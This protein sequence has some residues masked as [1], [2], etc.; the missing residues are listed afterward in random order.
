M[1]ST[2][3]DYDILVVG[4]GLSGINTS[5]RLQTEL[6][7]HRFA[8]LEARDKI[9]GTWSFWEYPGVRTDSPMGIFGLSWAPWTR[10]ENMADA[11]DI[12]N[13]MEDAAR[14][15]GIYDKIKFRHKVTAMRWDGSAGKNKWSLDVEI[16]SD[17]GTTRT[18]VIT[19]RWVVCCGGY[20]NYKQ[21]LETVIPG[22]ERFKGTVVHPQFW[23]EHAAAITGSTETNEDASSSENTAKVGPWA[24]KRVI[25]IGSGATAVT[26]LP[27]LA[28]MSKSVTILQRS[29][30]YVFPIPRR[31]G[32]GIFLRSILPLS[33]ASK[34]IWMRDIL[35]QEL[36]VAFLQ[37]FP[38]AGRKVIM[39]EIKKRMPK[40]FDVGTH[41]N[42][43]YRPFEQRLCLCPDGDFFEAFKK[44]GVGIVTD[45]IDTVTET[46]IKTASGQTLDAD[47]IITATGLRLCLVPA[48]I[49]VYISQDGQDAKPFSITDHFVWNG[50]M[51][52][53]VPNLGSIT[54]YTVGT[55]TPGA[56]A[57]A[58]SLIRVIKKADQLGATITVPEL[59]PELKKT[60]PRHP[61][62]PNSSTYLVTARDRMPVSSGTAPWTYPNQWL[63]DALFMWFGNVTKGLKFS[64]IK[65]KQDVVNGKV[66]T[67]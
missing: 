34:I 16:T 20:Y 62:L 36:F 58:R 6:P 30:S 61:I 52:E 53:N 42:P 2:D 32:L 37:T 14:T 21:A 55:W 39:S 67:A 5:Y 54:A 8:V 28:E 29:P 17:E 11:R 50:F 4:A 41:F 47:V 64:G 44:P 35:R 13:Y 19:A 9:G 51:V 7:S 18:E 1:A 40:G 24:D 15:H 23:A 25:I 10:D 12:R 65:G 49:P 59:D 57:R 56:D 31:D 45:T 26:L 60:L 66:K 38:N 3:T 43:K 33:L 48:D 27:S 63:T 22:I 46:G